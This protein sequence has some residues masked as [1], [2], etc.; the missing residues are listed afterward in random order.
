[1]RFQLRTEVLL[2]CQT[3][4]D[5]TTTATNFLYPVTCFDSPE[6]IASFLFF[7]MRHSAFYMNTKWSKIGPSCMLNDCQFQFFWANSRRV[8]LRVLR[9]PCILN[10]HTIFL[11]TQKCRVPI[12]TLNH[13]SLLRLSLPTMPVLAPTITLATAYPL[14]RL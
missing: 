5:A 8:L 10:G 1:M 13:C 12:T 4:T 3:R 6:L 11:I 14:R 7:L 2:E 9:I